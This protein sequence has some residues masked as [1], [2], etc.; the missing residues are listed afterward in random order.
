MTLCMILVVE[1]VAFWLQQ[2]K[3]C[4]NLQE[5]IWASVNI[6]E[7]HKFVVVSCAPTYS[8][9]LVQVCASEETVNPIYTMETASIMPKA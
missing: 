3:G 9:M 5:M 6:S 8:L 1:L 2:C 4:L 7:S